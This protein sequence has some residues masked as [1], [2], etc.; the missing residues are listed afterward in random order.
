MND[1]ELSE[2]NKKAI[3]V[4]KSSDRYFKKN[5][6]LI[7]ENCFNEDGSWNP[8]FSLQYSVSCNIS[9]N[10]FNYKN[11]VK[12]H[13]LIRKPYQENDCLKDIANAYN[14]SKMIFSSYNIE[15]KVNKSDFANIVLY[16][17]ISYIPDTAFGLPNY[18]KIPHIVGE[19]DLIL[20][21]FF[22]K[23]K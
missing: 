18:G 9:W 3:A 8:A 2:L 5:E 17:H 23:V 6:Y 21:D 10:E 19:K 22:K 1:I 11:Q 4:V 16:L 12:F 20:H 15:N 7:K 13:S 14:T